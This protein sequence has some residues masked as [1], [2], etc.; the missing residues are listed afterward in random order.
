MLGENHLLT[1]EF[2]EFSEAIT[3]LKSE[4]NNFS[5]MVKQYHRLDHKIRGLEMSSIPTTDSHFC[6]LKKE[7]L[8]LKDTLYKQLIKNGN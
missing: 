7:R 2:P 3:T 8:A 1:R 5:A 4:D 6:Q